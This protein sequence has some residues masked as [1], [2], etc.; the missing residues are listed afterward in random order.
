ME[1]SVELTLAPLQDDFKKP[2][3]DFI[4]ELRKSKF[5]VIENPLSTHIYGEYKSLMNFLTKS[6]E[7]SLFDQKS[8]IINIKILKNNRS[9]YNPNF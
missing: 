3:K 9:G 8:V 5:K 2:I 4:V 7:K 6:I 1:I